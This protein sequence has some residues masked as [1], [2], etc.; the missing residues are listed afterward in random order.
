MRGTLKRLRVKAVT[1]VGE[2]AVCK[3]GDAI[4]TT[5][6]FRAEGFFSFHSAVADTVLC[7]VSASF[8]GDVSVPFRGFNSDPFQSL[9]SKW[10]VFE[11]C[12]LVLYSS[13]T[14]AASL[15][16]PQVVA[17]HQV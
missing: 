13:M 9:Y 15:W 2:K 17:A 11:R 3:V 5:E 7:S 1:L 8:T 14:K 10:F 12:S 4:P 16:G 6:T